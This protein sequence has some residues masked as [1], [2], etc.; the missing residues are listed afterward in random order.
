M[1]VDDKDGQAVQRTRWCRHLF[2]HQLFDGETRIIR[3]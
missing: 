1:I 3:H 2:L